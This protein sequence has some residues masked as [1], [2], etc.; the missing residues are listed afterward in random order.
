MRT[1]NWIKRLRVPDHTHEL[2]MNFERDVQQMPE[3]VE[4]TDHLSKAL[5]KKSVK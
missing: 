2:G 3:S 5:K 1:A 4:C